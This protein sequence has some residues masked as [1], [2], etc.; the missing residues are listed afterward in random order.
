MTTAFRNVATGA[1]D[2]GQPRKRQ[3]NWLAEHL[4]DAEQ[5]R[6]YARDKC[7]EAVAATLHRALEGANLNRVTLAD[8]LGKSK[9]HV[10]RLL[11][12]AHNMTLR[13]LGDVL[14]ACDLEVVNFDLAVGQLGVIEV[15]VDDSDR[16]MDVNAIAYSQTRSPPVLPEQ[17]LVLQYLATGSSR[18]YATSNG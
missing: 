4:P 13:T 5:Q 11:G 6:D 9:S 16:W 17:V 10:S 7:V 18:A 2:L 1:L 15:A 14:W 12:G 3:I 8:K